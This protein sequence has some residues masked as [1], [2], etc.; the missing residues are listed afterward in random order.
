M[1]TYNGE[2]YLREQLNSF[3]AQDCFSQVKVLIRDD[4]STDGT[5][6]I[7]REYADKYNFEIIKGQNIGVNASMCELFSLCDLS[8][9]YFALSDQDDVW[10][11]DKLGKAVKELANY[12][13]Q[14]AMFASASIITD[15]CLKT[16]GV[17][18]RAK[19]GSSYYNAVV[20][21]ICPGHTQVFSKPLMIELRDTD[22]SEISVIDHW[23]YLLASSLGKIIFSEKPT[24]LHR[25]HGNN[26]VGYNIN[27][28]K[29][30]I[31][32]IKRVHFKEADRITIQLNYFLNRFQGRIPAE[33]ENEAI[34]FLNSR[35]L[36][37]RIK[38]SLTTKLF[39]QSFIDNILFRILFV[40]GKYHL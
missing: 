30:T 21:N 13:K 19:K 27:P 9:Q 3:I 37:Q 11:P 35:T 8:C 2:K 18:M 33:Y 23:I 10:L 38:Y 32:R 22:P 34:R 6:E 14:C 26:A 5:F 40:L 29:K 17:S 39:R 24:V 36:F 20:Q 7:L 4:G 25:Q 28:I 31:S 15:S 12:N 1:S 16:I